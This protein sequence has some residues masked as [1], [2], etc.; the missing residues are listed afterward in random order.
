MFVIQ[1]DKSK[2]TVIESEIL[3]SNAVDVYLIRFTFSNDW[4]GFSKVAIFYNNLEDEPKRYSV[5]I[6]DSG[7]VSIPREVLTDVGG[8]VYVGICGEG[9][10]FEHLPTLVIALGI[11]QQGIC[12]DATS[13]IDP[14]PTIYQQILSELASIKSDIASGLLRGPEG[15]RGPKGEQGMPGEKGDKGDQGDPGP[16]GDAG[17]Q[18]LPGEKGDKGDP[19]EI[20]NI[21]I[22]PDTMTY[23]DGVLS[24]LKDVI[25]RS[26][27][28]ETWNGMSDEDKNGLVFVELPD[29]YQG[30]YN[31][32]PLQDS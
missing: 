24:V 29:D 13:I 9:I 20:E 14:T 7:I 17:E 32:I 10:S 19:G 6:G 3:V 31:A 23:N 22:D 11:V 25:V 2:L 28:L 4:N 12:G 5:L 15:K 30:F 8:K 16:K 18:G 26:V 27:D 1:V 21:V